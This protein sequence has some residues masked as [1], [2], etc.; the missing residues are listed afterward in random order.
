MLKRVHRAGASFHSARLARI[1]AVRTASVAT[2]KI[3]VAE[4][5]TLKE[6]HDQPGQ[7]EAQRMKQKAWSSDEF[8]RCAELWSRG[9]LFLWQIAEK[10]GRSRDSISK[11]MRKNRVPRGSVPAPVRNFIMRD[12][13]F[14]MADEIEFLTTHWGKMTA[15]AI[16]EHL[17]RNRCSVIGKAG[18]L[19]LSDAPVGRP[20]AAK[21]VVAPPA[22]PLPRPVD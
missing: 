8:A 21:P 2:A 9:G 15:R 7:A 22:Q 4:T 19:H 13:R 11:K 20:L 14:W 10:L 3:A 17:G 6:P 16:G 18:R 5:P 12:A 1:A